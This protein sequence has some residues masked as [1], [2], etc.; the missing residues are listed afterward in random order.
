MAKHCQMVAKIG[1]VNS[2]WDKKKRGGGGGQLQTKD[3]IRA[4]AYDLCLYSLYLI[5]YMALFI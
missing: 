5:G 4:L 2:S 3:I 1:T